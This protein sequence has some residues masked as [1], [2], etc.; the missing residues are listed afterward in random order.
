VIERYTRFDG[1]AAERIAGL[2]AGA[3]VALRPGDGSHHLP[4]AQSATGTLGA[5]V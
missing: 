2:I 3:A 5:G 4:T 1:R